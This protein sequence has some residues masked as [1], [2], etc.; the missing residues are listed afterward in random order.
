MNHSAKK[1]LARWAM[2]K[3]VESGADQVKIDLVRSRKVDV[4]FRDNRVEN[5]ADALENKLTV[6]L[7]VDG[8]YGVHT[9]SDLRK[10][11]LAP[12][13]DQAVA[14]T[15]YLARD[16]HRALPE[17]SDYPE[18]MSKGPKDLDLMDPVYH[19]MTTDRRIDFATAVYE[20]A[21][22]NNKRV[23]S[24]KALFFDRFSESVKI[25]SNGFT[26]ESSA[27]VFGASA[28]VSVKGRDGRRPEDW[29]FVHTRF[30]EDLPQA[31]Y[32]GS[33]AAGRAVEKIGQAPIPSGKY[34]V[35]VEN[36]CAG[37]L[38][39]IIAGALNA[40]S[41]QQKTS[42]LEG[43]LNQPIASKALTVVDDPF[44]KRGMG[45]KFYDAEGLEMKK[46]II[47]R[48]GI[49]KTY[50]VDT[51]YGKK[52]G[53]TPNSATQG[54]IL[55]QPSELSLETLMARMDNGILITG[56]I[57]GN[58]NPATGDFSLGIQG[59]LIRDGRRIRPVSEMNISGNAVDFW[60]AFVGPGNDPYPYSSTQV[61][62]LLFAGAHISGA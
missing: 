49:L 50:Y 19:D 29:C 38:Y 44:V 1:D 52:L 32:I 3:A 8:R 18:D 47:I 48:Q 7:F 60:K 41:L 22:D 14:T 10:T 30:F 9:T 43:R 28:R 16:P 36:R 5:L 12:F 39:N 42:F 40:R 45:S 17:A 37:R 21:M 33:Q 58:N 34:D 24:T 55:I 25:C 61:P 53:M 6:T 59:V 56:F 54:N 35:I 20:A 4:G 27:T 31:G 23:I 2:A 11:A 26:G 13:I 15:R 51:Y 62:S 46:R 57:G